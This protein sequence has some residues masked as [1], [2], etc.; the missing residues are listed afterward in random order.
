MAQSD[1]YELHVDKYAG[2]EIGIES[3]D[4]AATGH[5]FL[6]ILHWF[7]ADFYTNFIIPVELGWKPAI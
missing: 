3:C 1:E 5:T 6:L 7:Y 2:T 4:F